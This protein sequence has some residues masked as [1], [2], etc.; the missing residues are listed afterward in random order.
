MKGLVI[1]EEMTSG[2]QILIGLCC[3]INSRLQKAF[4][5]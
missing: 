3:Q 4:V 5:R 2:F 1:D